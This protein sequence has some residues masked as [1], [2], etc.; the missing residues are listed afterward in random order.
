MY[1]HKLRAEADGT[2]YAAFINRGFN[3][4]E[5]IGAYVRFNLNELPWLCQWKMPGAQTYVTGIEPA[6][7]QGEGRPNERASGRMISIAPGDQRSYSL[8]IGVLVGERE[9][10]EMEE[11]IAGL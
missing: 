6:S 2:T 9:I 3:G 7:G 4:G 11:L 8:E 10:G 1:Y 5:G